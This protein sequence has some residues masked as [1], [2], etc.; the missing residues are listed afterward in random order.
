MRMKK[1]LLKTVL[2]TALALATCSAMA[3]MDA[4]HKIHGEQKIEAGVMPT[5]QKS[6]ERK[7][8]VGASKTEAGKA[9]AKAIKTF[10]V[11]KLN[12]SK[13]LDGDKNF[14]KAEYKGK[15]FDKL[16]RN[17]D[18]KIDYLDVK[19]VNKSI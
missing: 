9:E 5:A 1:S 16:D 2:A 4:P 8:Q 12:G 18:G 11:E 19:Y 15:D 13:D 17:H 6:A 14:T 3:E 7:E 10:P